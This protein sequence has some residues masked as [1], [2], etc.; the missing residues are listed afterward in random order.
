MCERDI[1]RESGGR[2]TVR[3]ID[4]LVLSRTVHVAKGLFVGCLTSSNMR[5][6]LRDGSDQTILHH[7]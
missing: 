6:Y 4:R 5:V 7:T 2:Q 3:K 1:G